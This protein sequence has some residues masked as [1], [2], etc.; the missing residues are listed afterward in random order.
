VSL[1]TS[2]ESSSVSFTLARGGRETGSDPQH[3]TAA[4]F[5]ADS[6]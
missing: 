3:R 1:T 5:A 4:C 2:D 6:L